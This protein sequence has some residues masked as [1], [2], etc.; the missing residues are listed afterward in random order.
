MDGPERRLYPISAGKFQDH[1]KSVDL[2]WGV[3]GRGGLYRSDVDAA[4]VR[5]RAR[6]SAA[7]R[8]CDCI[9]SKAGNMHVVFNKPQALYL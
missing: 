8:Q 7:K 5:L 3:G 2:A 9:V 6:A 4:E 1:S